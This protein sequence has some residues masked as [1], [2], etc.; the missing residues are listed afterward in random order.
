MIDPFT[1]DDLKRLSKIKSTPCVSLYMPCVIA[2]RET[3][4]NHI[5]FKNL[6]EDAEK[7]LLQRGLRENEIKPYL[8]EARQLFDDENFW[9]N[10]ASGFAFFAT[11]EITHYYRL[12]LDCEEIATVSG[13][14]YIRPLIPLF[15][16]N[17]PF[18]L[19]YLSMN[20][21]VLY[22]VSKTIFEKQ[23]VPDLPE[24]IEA[25]LKYDQ[26]ERQLQSHSGRPKDNNRGAMFHGQE[27]EKRYSQQR[28][29]QFLEKV[30]NA[31]TAYIGNSTTPLLLAG[32]PE[33]LS[34]YRDCSRY[35]HLEQIQIEKDMHSLSDHEFH[36]EVLT[37]YK[38]RID[39]IVKNAVDRFGDER[40]A[41][42]TST[43]I[44]NIV[45]AARNSKI[46]TLFYRSGSHLWADLDVENTEFTMHNDKMSGDEELINFAAVETMNHG[47]SVFPLEEQQ[48][49]GGA[50]VAAINRY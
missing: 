44:N 19:L 43:D 7:Q 27:D 20:S 18:Y 9:K 15:T 46:D 49:P 30:E 33:Y 16:L 24:D 12:P 23:N 48:M 40:Q 29:R 36:R 28:I 50:V 1:Q 8:A 5:R 37:A 47:G 41:G 2:G 6:A 17:K 21:V 11:S 42:K 34:V 31:V 22:L 4:Q 25:V 10:Q 39:E 14:F 38:P 45:P 32:L 13:Y 3:R 35:S 26:P